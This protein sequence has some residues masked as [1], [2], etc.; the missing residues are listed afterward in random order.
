MLQK[1]TE[2]L[3]VVDDKAVN[4]D[5][6]QSSAERFDTVYARFD[7]YFNP[8]DTKIPLFEKSEYYYTLIRVKKQA[9]FENS[10]ITACFTVY[11]PYN[12]KKYSKRA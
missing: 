12:V 4:A 2:L 9:V 3:R 8:V 1:L 7:E 10:C 11:Y 5:S 6:K